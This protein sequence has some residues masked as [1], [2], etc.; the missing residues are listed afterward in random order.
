MLLSLNTLRE[1]Q[2][3]KHSRNR[4]K[5][6]EEHWRTRTSPYLILRYSLFHKLRKIKR[7]LLGYKQK[8]MNEF[9]SH[10]LS[11]Y[12]NKL[13]HSRLWTLSPKKSDQFRAKHSDT[14]QAQVQS[15]TLHTY[16]GIS[17]RKNKLGVW[18]EDRPWTTT[19]YLWLLAV[20]YSV[21][22]IKNKTTYIFT[23]KCVEEVHLLHWSSG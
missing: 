13:L 22:Y 11:S 14:V 19:Q 6:P 2:E 12:W 10:L 8:G 20:I 16:S 7:C 4:G 5:S 15:T 18:C 1:I 3:Y 21:L 17:S 9:T 23:I